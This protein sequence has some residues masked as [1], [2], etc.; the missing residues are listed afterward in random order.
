M[1]AGSSRVEIK[2]PE[3]TC[4]ASLLGV[5]HLCELMMIHS[6]LTHVAF[7]LLFYLVFGI[8]CLNLMCGFGFFFFCFFL[9]LCHFHYMSY[10]LNLIITIFQL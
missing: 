1:I 9:L 10:S 7:V 8:V 4:L 6:N 3:G 2:L 5:G